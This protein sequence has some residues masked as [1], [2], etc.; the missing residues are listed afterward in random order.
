[1]GDLADDL[2]DDLT[3]AR[4]V[5]DGMLAEDAMSQWL[6]VEITEIRPG[7]CR[8]EM[9]VRAEM[10]NGHKTLHGGVCFAFADST[11]AFACNARNKTTVAAGCDIVY[12]APG[13]LGDVLSAE[14]REIHL[15]GRS[16]VYDVTVTNQSGDVVGLFR[17]K[18]RT[19]RGET[20]PGL[21]CHD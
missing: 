18:S 7:Y 4:V 11:F 10:L 1:M 14:A 5:A 12:P 17:G 3:L 16:G 8:A 6:G 9:T 15:A 2:T 19:I 21:K 13:R 20:V